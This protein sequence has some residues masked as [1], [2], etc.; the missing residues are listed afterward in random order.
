MIKS[1]QDNVLLQE[2]VESLQQTFNDQ[3]TTYVHELTAANTMVADLRIQLQAIDSN[4]D[5]IEAYNIAKAQLDDVLSAYNALM[6]EYNT[7][8]LDYDNLKDEYQQLTSAYDKLTIASNVLT[9]TYSKLLN[10]CNSIA[11]LHHDALVRSFDGYRGT[12]AKLSFTAREKLEL[13]QLKDVIGL[14]SNPAPLNKAIYEMYYRDKIKTLLAEKGLDS[15]K[16]GIYR[17]WMII[18]DIEYSYVGQ[19]VDIGERW[20]QHLKR[21]VGSEPATGIKLY[22]DERINLSELN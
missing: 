3:L 21:L 18:D 22:K 7:S 6:V 19:S 4:N 14:L 20:I 10:S 9:S 15:R 2:K 11:Q 8:K 1:K 17:L 16:S 5:T 13:G 12:A